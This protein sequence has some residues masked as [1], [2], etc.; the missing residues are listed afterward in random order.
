MHY[1]QP[2]QY[3]EQTTQLRNC[4]GNSLIGIYCYVLLHEGLFKHLIDI[5]LVIKSRFLYRLAVNIL[6]DR[7][8]RQGDDNGLET[9]TD[10]G[11]Y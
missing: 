2:G 11:K 9:D 10:D 3:D 8:I 6:T 7:G 1:T 5:S 4:T